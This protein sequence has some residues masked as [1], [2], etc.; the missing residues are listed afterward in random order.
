MFAAGISFAV[1]A[2]AHFGLYGA[3]IID[4]NVNGDPAALKALFL[5]GAVIGGTILWLV[6][7]LFLV[8]ASYVIL[9]T[10]LLPRWTARVGFIA[11][12]LNVVSSLSLFGGGDTNGFFT[13]TGTVGFI[14]GDLPFVVW[15]VSVSIAMLGAPEARRAR[16][17]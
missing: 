13:A 9:Q 12:A 10:G 14:F 17:T 15:V 5:A 7:A 3:A 16:V 6:A 8:G 11:A 1:L 2:L 4:T